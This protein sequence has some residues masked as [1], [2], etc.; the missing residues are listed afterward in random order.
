MKL[1]KSIM[2]V[3]RYPKIKLTKDFQNVLT[4][5][6]SKADLDGNGTLSRFEI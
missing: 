5:I 2:F 6:F 1:K 3:L 4:D